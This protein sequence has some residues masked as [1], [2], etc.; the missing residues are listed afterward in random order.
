M[1]PRALRN[2]TITRDEE[3]AR[4]AHIKAA[5]NDTSISRLIAALLKDRMLEQDHYK[6][7]RRRA[8][9]RHSFPKSDR[10]Y[11]TREEVHEH[12]RLR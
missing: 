6:I 1:R 2:I 4:R 8:L 5:T 7:A 12:D 3:V 11:L 10:P 9:A